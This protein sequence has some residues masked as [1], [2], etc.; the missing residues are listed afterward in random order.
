[1]GTLG[2]RMSGLD[3]LVRVATPED[4]RLLADMGARTFAQAFGVDNDP[5]ELAAYL[6]SAF[7]P[8][9]Q[10]AELCDPANVFLVAQVG[11]ADAGYT[12]LRFAEAPTCVLGD[13]PAEIVR[14][15]ADQPWIGRGVGSALMGSCLALFGER[16]HDA[17]WLSVWERNQRGIAFYEKWGFA[18]VGRQVFHVGGDAQN[19]L[20]MS[21]LLTAV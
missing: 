2:P 7:G 6:A 13:R 17:A 12:K 15:Y 18:A 5:D 16:G 8:A 14:I 21:R 10:H 11:D 9:I 19:D 20:V 1:M 3:V 4:A